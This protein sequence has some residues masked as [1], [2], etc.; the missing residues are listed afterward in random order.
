MDAEVNTTDE[1]INH[2]CSSH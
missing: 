2:S 1:F